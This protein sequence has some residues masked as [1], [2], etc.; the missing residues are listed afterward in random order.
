RAANATSDI[1]RD[2]RSGH[3]CSEEVANRGTFMAELLFLAARRAGRPDDCECLD[4]GNRRNTSSAEIGGVVALA[5]N[6]AK[7]IFDV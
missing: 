7:R 1:P 3:A 6:A 2:G 4:F 5:P